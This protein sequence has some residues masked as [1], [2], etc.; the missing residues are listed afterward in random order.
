M[1]NGTMVEASR[2]RDERAWREAH[3]G[4]MAPEAQEAHA[5]RYRIYG[6]LSQAAQREARATQRLARWRREAC[7]RLAMALQGTGMAWCDHTP[8][9]GRSAPE[10]PLVK[11]CRYPRQ[12][13]IAAWLR[14]L[15]GQ[16]GSKEELVTA[17]DR[18]RRRARRVAKSLLRVAPSLV[19]TDAGLRA[20]ERL[21]AAIRARRGGTAA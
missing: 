15:A 12:R 21:I 3:F 8:R 9:T 5:R 13:A 14:I 10:A 20:M 16:R 7:R 19:Q 2:E 17:A 4:E 11:T 1:A 6:A 18:K